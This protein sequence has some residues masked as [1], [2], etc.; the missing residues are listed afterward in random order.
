MS[1]KWHFI[2]VQSKQDAAM[3]QVLDNCLEYFQDDGESFKSY[4][5]ERGWGKGKVASYLEGGGD[6]WGDGEAYGNGRGNGRGDG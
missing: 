2:G 5:I 6:G 3:S 4:V 1:M